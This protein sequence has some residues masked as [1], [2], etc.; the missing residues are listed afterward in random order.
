M[1]AAQAQIMPG[2]N[3]LDP[4]TGSGSLL[5]AASIRGAHCTGIDLDGRI[6]TGTGVG[7]LNYKSSFYSNFL[8]RDVI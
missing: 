2:Y 4:F 5:I 1:M 7:K 3:V 6:L 8:I